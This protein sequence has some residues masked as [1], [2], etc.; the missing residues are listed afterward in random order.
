MLPGIPHH[1]ERGPGEDAGRPSDRGR[2]VGAILAHTGTEPGQLWCAAFVA[3]V[4]FRTLGRAWPLPLSASCDVVRLAA[5]DKGMVVPTPERGDLFFVMKSV[6]DATHVGFVTAVR[7]DGS[8]STIEGNTNDAGSRDGD[9]VYRRRRGG[10]KDT[11]RFCSSAGATPCRCRA[12]LG[13]RDG[14]PMFF[15]RRTAIQPVAD[16]THC[17]CVCHGDGEQPPKPVN[18]IVGPGVDR[19]DAVAAATACSHCLK[20][21]V[22]ALTGHPVTLDLRARHAIR[23]HQEQKERD[24]GPASSPYK[25]D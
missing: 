18:G 11:T 5:Q 8:C 19:T 25:D 7:A 2:C 10:P 23:Q 20:Y 22:V 6:H 15:S 13:P 3:C 24:S 14:G 9:G 16:S 12:S 1:A 21:H 4:G 17:R